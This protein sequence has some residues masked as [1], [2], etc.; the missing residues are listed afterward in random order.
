M[1][2]T[3]CGYALWNLPAGT[4]PE[5]GRMFKPSDFEFRR[6]AVQFAC[7]A[8]GQT[9]YGTDERG[10]LVPREFACVQCGTATGMDAMI[11]RP[12]PGVAESA[13]T[14][15]AN[16]WERRANHGW[17][18][19][20][21]STI[22][23]AL[24]SP[25]RLIEATPAPGEPGGGTG[26]A[27]SF[28][29]TTL[30]LF[31]A[32]ALLPLIV[33]VVFLVLVGGG[34]AG[35]GLGACFGGMV[36][37]SIA[38]AAVVVAL[39]VPLTHALLR[40]T[41]PTEHG[42]GR[43]AQ[44]ILYG[45]GANVISAIPC[46]GQSIGYVGWA[47]W[48]VAATLMVMRG[49]RVSGGRAAFATITPPIATMIVVG[50]GFMAWVFVMSNSVATTPAPYLASETQTILSGVKNYAA[51]HGGDGP[52]H[53]AEL[54]ENG[55]VPP[56]SF[57]SAGTVTGVADVP[58]GGTTLDGWGGNP[59][60]EANA[61]R[62]AVSLQP[63]DVVAH[64]FGDFVFTHHGVALDPPSDGD[65]WLVVMWPDPRPNA[66]MPAPTQVEIGLA[67]GLVRTVNAGGFDADL[68]AQNVLRAQRGLPPL[69]H[70]RDVLHGHPATAPQ[71]E[72][73]E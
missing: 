59:I 49:Q 45:S 10:H 54:L 62:A 70:P 1:N 3:G 19:G 35:V 57:V 46:I 67:S 30:C 63:P 2:C 16:A 32:A 20:L 71:V 29:A 68:T 58:I 65:L 48:M 25:T 5:C 8:C 13:A 44:A 73:A 41:G 69:P 40:L 27:L 23:G 37:S 42:M 6:E 60:Q 72:A 9:Y 24:A 39:W 38:A 12:A 14:R 11:V 31:H 7:R 21:T 36:V 55:A 17:W 26:G 18:R 56:W 15:E 50:A 22:G 52:A 51:S 43:T 34:A 64:R 4:C 47:W 53:A 66:G 33:F 28:F 61:I